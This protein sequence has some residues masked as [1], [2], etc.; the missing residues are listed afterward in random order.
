MFDLVAA[1]GSSR[2][3]V[4]KRT[5]PISTFLLPFAIA[6]CLTESSRADTA[7]PMLMSVKPVAVQVG[8]TTQTTISSRYS[9]AG[10]YQVLVSGEG[11]KGEVVPLDTKQEDTAKKP[12]L[13]KL[14]VKFIVSTDAMPGVRDVRIA[15]PQGV[16]TV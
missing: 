9:M 10:A 3:F 2:G 1:K 8:T 4:V 15:T 6:C 14:K 13:E 12:A 5:R 11:V 16:S 7:Y